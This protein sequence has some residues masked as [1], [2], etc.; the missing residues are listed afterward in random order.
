MDT[1]RTGMAAAPGTGCSGSADDG[2]PGL[3]VGILLQDRFTLNAMAGF[4]DCLRLAADK[5]GR[6]RPIYCAWQ[7]MAERPVT[8]S[9]G[10]QVHADTEL[11]TPE[12]FDY[13]A[14]CGGNAYL[15]PREGR[16]LHPYL[17]AAAQA[18][19]RLIGICTGT[20]TL[21]R[22]GL[23]NGY[24]AC[25]H[26]NVHDAFQAEFPGIQALP[27]RLFLDA[28]ARITCAGS[29]GATD[30]A[31][32]LIRRHCGADKAAQAIR[33]MMLQDARPAHH[34][35]AHFHGDMA[36]MRDSRL[37]R[38]VHFMEQSLNERLT[39][40]QIAAAVNLSPRQL[41][42]LFQTALGSGPL[43]YFRVM[44]LRYAHWL[45]QHSETRI[46]EIAAEVGFADSAHFARAFRVHFGMTP[47][48]ARA[49]NALP[50]GTPARGNLPAQT[51]TANP[52]C[53]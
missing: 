23:M 52:A 15:D 41:E 2:R 47:Q 45:L 34:P 37:R 4:V 13:I 6:S 14:V 38:A 33:H 21:A 39:S 19:V 42:R 26:W 1:M 51:P 8:A 32:H 9:C 10:M 7:I 53:R 3:R 11:R 46:A 24:R 49:A 25:V 27:D 16:S 28:G 36:T 40:A 29:S 17:Q 5:G 43:A 18:S 30:L 48:A 35:Q 22:A 12:A 20:F 44:R 31:L 50:T